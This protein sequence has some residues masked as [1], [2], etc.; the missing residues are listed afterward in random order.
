MR[1]YSLDGLVDQ[2]AVRQVTHLMEKREEVSTEI[3]R[4]EQRALKMAAE[5]AFVVSNRLAVKLCRTR[6]LKLW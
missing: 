6:P 1:M 4:S 2:D 3:L 5:A